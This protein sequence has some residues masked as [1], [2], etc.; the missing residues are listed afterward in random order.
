MNA[1]KQRLEGRGAAP[2]DVQKVLA[3]HKAKEEGARLARTQAMDRLDQD[4]RAARSTGDRERVRILE[5][6]RLQLHQTAQ[7]QFDTTTHSIRS[8]QG[9]I[10][11]VIRQS[12]QRPG[13]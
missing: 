7:R 6:Q 10:K 12:F 4:I 1:A 3:E 8:Q 9:K 5:A 2:F 13:Q 11:S